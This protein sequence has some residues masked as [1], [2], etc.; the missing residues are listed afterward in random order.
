MKKSRRWLVMAGGLS[1]LL[2]VSQGPGGAG[3]SKPPAFLKEPVRTALAGLAVPF[4]ANRGQFDDN[5]RF[6][7]DLLCGTLDVTDD[8]LN[9]ALGIVEGGGGPESPRSR[10]GDRDPEAAPRM[11]TAEFREVFLNG[12]GLPVSFDARGTAK[13][14]TRVSYFLGNNPSAW[15][16]DVPSFEKISLGD[17][18][19]GIEV[20]LKASTR[21]VEKV[22][23]CGPGA[24]PGRIRILVEGARRLSL[25]A[26]GQLAVET[27]IG[28]IALAAPAAYQEGEGGRRRVEIGYELRGENGYGFR[29]RGS[30]DA[31]RH[32]V[33]DPALET[34]LASTYFGT[35]IDDGAQALAFD[36]RGNILGAGYTF[37]QKNRKYLGIV[38]KL[39]SDLSALLASAYIGG[40]KTG[41]GFSINEVAALA[42][43]PSGDVTLA[44]ITNCPDFPTTAGAYDTTHNGSQD[45]FVARL[46]A[47]LNKVRASTLIG[48]DY[49][50]QPFGLALDAAENIYVTGTTAS[51]RYP[52]TPGAFDTSYN[53]YPDVFVSSFDRSLSRLLASTFMGGT[54]SNPEEGLGCLVD[55]A[56]RVYVC[57]LTFS[58]N[59]P[60]TLGAYDRRPN[61]MGDV[62]VAK[63]EP[64]LKTLVASTFLGGTDNDFVESMALDGLG[65]LYLAGWT[66]SSDF[67]VTPGAYDTTFNDTDP[68]AHDAFVARLDGGLGTLLAST[69]LGGEIED[70]AHAVALNKVGNVYV[71]GWTRSA[72][73]PATPGAYDTTLN[74]TGLEDMFVSK[75]NASLSRL[76][77]S[78]FLGGSGR[79]FGRALL[80]DGIG[81]IYV[82]G[83]T[84]STDFPVTERAADTTPNGKT[85]I[86][87]SKFRH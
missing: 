17:V 39:K 58:G 21:T 54:S 49:W 56:G 81:D 61:G 33:I 40:D 26:A 1:I 57:G 46:G 60:T 28:E 38:F 42:V 7:A 15:R 84:A 29:I 80:I 63:F 31:A 67:P 64:T 32:L 4:V 62:F 25:T 50:E 34:L 86:I 35:A 41:T 65:R 47:G 13:S 24:D 44:G 53:D 72:G 73:F 70:E 77:V 45:V 23:S 87:V 5:V 6:S 9:Y 74:A 20:E 82:A 55:H 52:V 11:R 10:R 69:F 75:F 18:W 16:A 51:K 30:Y 14:P 71:A 37:D 76:L 22:F 19:P 8:S 79:D 2:S 59:F 66:E 12:E 83:A 68:N 36:R 3:A 85:D 27:G 78:T 43:G 48:A